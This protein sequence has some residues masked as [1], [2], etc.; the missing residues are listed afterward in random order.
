[1]LAVLWGHIKSK[2]SSGF[3]LMLY[4]FNVFAMAMLACFWLAGVMFIIFV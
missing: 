4:H 1:M 3:R 2:D